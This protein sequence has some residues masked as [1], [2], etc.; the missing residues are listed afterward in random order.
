MLQRIR[1]ILIRGVFGLVLV[2][3]GVLACAARVQH[4]GAIPI[5]SGVGLFVVA[6]VAAAAC[7]LGFGLLGGKITSDGTGNESGMF[8]GFVGSLA[9]YLLSLGACAV[10]GWN[11]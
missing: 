9:G 1:E 6:S 4:A 8:G 5:L 2:F 3:P 11:L 7:V 10:G